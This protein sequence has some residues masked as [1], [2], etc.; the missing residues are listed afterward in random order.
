MNL[1]NSARRSRWTHAFFGSLATLAAIGFACL[2]A[3][4]TP[5]PGLLELTEVARMPV[6]GGHVN[7]AGGNYFHA[8]ASLSLDTRLGEYSLGAVYN[9]AWGW[10][11]GVD[12]SYKN[13]TLRDAT[14]ARMPLASLANGAAAPGTHWVKLD[15]TRVKTKGGLVHEF[16]AGTS[17]L[18]AIHWSSAPYPRLVFVPVQIGALTRTAR[19]EQCTSASACTLAFALTHDSG[20]R[21]VRIDDRAGRSALFTYAGTQLVAA[22]DGLDVAKQWPG[23]RYEYANGFLAAIVNSEGERIEIASDASGRATQVRAVGAGDPSWR[24]SY[25]FPGATGVATTTATDPLGKAT[26]FTIDAFYRVQ[27]ITNPLGE[28]TTYTWS[29]QRPASRLLPD[30]TR[31]T[32]TWVNDDIASETLPSGNVRTFAYYPDGENRAAPRARALSEIRDSIGPSASQSYDAS[33]RLVEIANGAAEATQLTYGADG[34]IVSILDPN[35]TRRVFSGFG[36][37]GHATS[38][39]YAT[40]PAVAVSAFDAVGNELRTTAPDPQSG[41]VRE[42]GYDADRN[43]ATAEL[44]DAPLSGNSS[45]LAVAFEHRSDG[46]LERVVRPYGGATRFV[47]DAAGR[48][49]AIEERVSPGA[50]ATPS[51]STTTIERDLLGRVTAVSWA[52]G[53]RAETEYDAAG[54]VVRK[55]SLRTGNVESDVH[56]EYQAGRLVRSYDASGFDE[57]LSYDSAGR[58]SEVRYSEGDT[59]RLTYDERSRLTRSDLAMAS[60]AP[61]ATLLHRYD[62]ADR[63]IGVDT[64]SGALVTRTYVKGQLE[65]TDY[66]NGLTTQH[67]RNRSGTRSAG[68]EVWRGGN[69]IAKSTWTIAVV[70]GG[71]TSGLRT[72]VDDGTSADGTSEENFSYAGDP[73]GVG[74]ER[75]LSASAQLGMSSSAEAFGYDHLSNLTGSSNSFGAAQFA[76]NSERNRLLSA[77]HTGGG[78]VP[79]PEHTG[80]EYDEA[81]FVVREARSIFGQIANDNRFFWT[82]RG[83]IAA[84]HANGVVAASFRYDALGRRRERVANGVV[85]RWRFGGLVEADA[86]DAPTALDFGEVRIQLDGNHRFRLMDARGNPKLATS[87]NGRVVH[88]ASYSGYARSVVRGSWSDPRSFAGGAEIT[89]GSAKYV[90]IGARLYDPRAARFLAPDPIWQA[91]NAFSY[92]LGNPVDFGDPSGLHSGSHHDLAQAALSVAAKTLKLGV[93]VI[94]LA[95]PPPISFVAVVAVAITALELADAAIELDQQIEL[96]RAQT[97]AEGG[98]TGIG[99]GDLQPS[100]GAWTGIWQ[101]T[102]SLRPNQ[103]APRVCSSDQFGTYCGSGGWFWLPVAKSQPV[104]WEQ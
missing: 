64:L 23:E 8:A 87:A 81:G 100:A 12:A 6:P 101:Q 22:R 21:I 70:P 16:D 30:G 54:R 45:L 76:Y 31:T 18:A 28:R 73:S 39:G 85:T 51:L 79:I 52:N 84:I 89:A 56:F 98:R 90:L 96:H 66:A 78:F 74:M 60:G 37:H 63:E 92:T 20:G 43:L 48:V 68:A 86:S 91:I 58:V 32:W 72:V 80:F 61:L 44:I 7:T 27:S 35:V 102:L 3:Q 4:L 67:F 47:F 69:R 94:A 50:A 33:G 38:E 75:R 82:A 26:A 10:T 34:E 15:A 104:T 41:G 103:G 55:R 5:T 24:F 40:E 99:S 29:G 13:G 19:I 9:S 65:T 1:A 36:E 77:T 25:G 95:A 97:A 71:E 83:A 93:A 11:F 62:G 46:Q 49:R 42:R 14:G 53:M 59:L 57:R 2:P 17:R 88:H